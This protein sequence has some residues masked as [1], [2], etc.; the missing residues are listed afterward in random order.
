MLYEISPLMLNTSS[1][2]F[3][4]S[5]IHKNVKTDVRAGPVQKATKTLQLLKLNPGLL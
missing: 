4:L 1:K 3:G 2:N 5:G